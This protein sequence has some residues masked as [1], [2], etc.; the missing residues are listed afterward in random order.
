MINADYRIIMLRKAK[1]KY[2]IL[3]SNKDLLSGTPLNEEQQHIS[4]KAK[5]EQ[6]KATNFKLSKQLMSKL[7]T[8]ASS[9]AII[10]E[11]IH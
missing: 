11:A 6:F 7:K 10:H 3:L 2:D 8:S 1:T 5:L 4:L 9:P